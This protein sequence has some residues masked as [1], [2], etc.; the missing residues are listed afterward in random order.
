MASQ[1]LKSFVKALPDF[2]NNI[3][4]ALISDWNHETKFVL[5]DAKKNV[6]VAAGF[7]RGSGKVTKKALIM[8]SSKSGSSLT[9]LLS[10]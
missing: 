9:K 8:S 10:V 7:L 2:D 5:D 6:P 3:V 1:T 4:T